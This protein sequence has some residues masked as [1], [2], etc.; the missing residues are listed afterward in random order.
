MTRPVLQ[1][2]SSPRLTLIGMAML[3]VGAALSYDNPAG[4]SVWVLV[5]PMGFLSLNL[6]AAIIHNPRIHQRGGLLVFHL[7]LLGIVI[8]AAFGRL[9]RLEA[10]TELVE[11][12][13]FDKDSLI[14]VREGPMHRAGLDRVQFVQGTYTVDY[15]AGMVRG[16]THCEV[17]VPAVNGWQRLDVGD[18]RPLVLN[19]YRFYT[20]FN[21]GFAAVLSW[22]PAG[23]GAPIRGTV[24]MPAYPLYDFRQANRW[25]PREGEEIRFWLDL[26]TGLTDK[27]AWTL[28]P[29]KTKAS[30]IV[31]SGEQR[32]TLKAGDHVRLAGGVLTFE[33]LSSWMG[34][35]IF[36][37]PTISWLFFTAIIGVIG[38]AGHFWQK[39]RQPDWQP[40]TKTQRSVDTVSGRVTT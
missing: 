36:Y 18:D 30:L 23:G 33:R 38:L 21:K 32:V 27:Q 13:A 26:D 9:T 39:L 1:R 35:K 37:D 3:G 10:H 25:E 19:G 11:G 5:V 24:N 15:A 12:T 7:C 8:L 17:L 6:L 31:K 22:L 14:D 2:L 29:A 34:Y 16:L 20:T 28:A 4:T 40:T